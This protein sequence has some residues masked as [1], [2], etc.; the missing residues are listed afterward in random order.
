MSS[1]L[2][3]AERTLR[4]RRA[5][6]VRWSKHDSH[7]HAAKMREGLERRFFDQVDPNRSLPEGERRRR[8]EQ[9]RK[10]HYTDLAYKSAR[11][12]RKAAEDAA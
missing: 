2:T 1:D 6:H 9:A 8:A 5:A 12:R 3:P 10:A 7:A 11:A 4:A